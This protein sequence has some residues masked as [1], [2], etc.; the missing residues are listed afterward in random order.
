MGMR[1]LSAVLATAVGVAAAQDTLTI[2][3]D[4]RSVKGPPI[5]PNFVG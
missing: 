4:V 3:V 1:G 5:A 2:D